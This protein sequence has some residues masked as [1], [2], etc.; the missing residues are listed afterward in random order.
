MCQFPTEKPCALW[1]MPSYLG[2]L[3]MCHLSQGQLLNLFKAPSFRLKCVSRTPLKSCSSAY[4]NYFMQYPILKNYVVQTWKSCIT[5]SVIP[6]SSDWV[7]LGRNVKLS[8]KWAMLVFCNAFLVQC[9]SVSRKQYG[10][11]SML[12]SAV[13]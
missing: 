6:W 1:H 4:L 10:P 3:K 12:Y 8:G 13:Y 7:T 11:V 9:K 5:S 2:A